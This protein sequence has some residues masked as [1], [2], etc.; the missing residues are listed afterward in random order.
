MSLDEDR[1]VYLEYNSGDMYLYNIT[2]N[3]LM[4]VYGEMRNAYKINKGS[5][6]LILKHGDSSSYQNMININHY[7]VN[8]EK[9]IEV[10]VELGTKWIL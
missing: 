2:D 9:S 1:Y 8:L 7:I 6:I 4:T 5:Y 3:V 10:K